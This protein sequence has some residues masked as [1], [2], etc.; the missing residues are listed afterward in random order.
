MT[1]FFAQLVGGLQDDFDTNIATPNQLRVAWPNAPFEESAADVVWADLQVKSS[2]DDEQM[3]VGAVVK[4]YRKSGRLHVNLY[5]QPETGEG[6]ALA[7]ADLIAARYRTVEIAGC[8]FDTPTI[9]P[10]TLTGPWWRTTIRCP[11]DAQYAA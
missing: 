6:A 5:S 2:G 11:F 3:D 9:E 8:S 4:D 10:G 7:L 1:S